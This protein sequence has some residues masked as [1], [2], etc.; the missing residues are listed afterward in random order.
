MACQSRLGNACRIIVVV[1]RR[2]TSVITSVSHGLVDRRIRLVELAQVTVVVRL[3]W[4]HRLVQLV[5]TCLRCQSRLL[6][7]RELDA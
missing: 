1:D 3:V 4:L 5:C 6:L 7:I 2:S